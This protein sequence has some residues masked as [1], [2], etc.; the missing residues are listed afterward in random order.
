MSGKIVEKTR[1]GG[2][3]LSTKSVSFQTITHKIN[4]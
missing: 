2:V 1:V 3:G 4:V